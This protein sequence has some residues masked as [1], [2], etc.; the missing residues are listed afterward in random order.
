MENYSLKEAF[1]ERVN[2]PKRKPCS[3]FLQE[4]IDGY[5]TNI[6]E[7]DLT[8]EVLS[9][10]I[11]EGICEMRPIHAY[12][13]TYVDKLPKVGESVEFDGLKS[14]S[15]SQVVAQGFAQTELDYISQNQNSED[16]AVLYE[17]NGNMNS[18]IPLEYCSPYCYITYQQEDEIISMDMSYVVESV[19]PIPNASEIH[20]FDSATLHNKVNIYKIKLRQYH[21]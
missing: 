7:S 18:F 21:L 19:E 8:E 4:Y 15:R 10:I 2:I 3:Q 11:D 12:R 17:V 14:W 1:F 5:L 9:V 6:R 16:F 20:S 13:G